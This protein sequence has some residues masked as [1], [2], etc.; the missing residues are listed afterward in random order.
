LTFVHFWN[1]SATPT[2]TKIEL[3]F[4]HFSL[5]GN[6]A[7][8]Q[9]LPKKQEKKGEKIL[10]TNKFAAAFRIPIPIPLALSSVSN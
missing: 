9:N 3:K 1:E 5:A 6:K 2:Q 10:P 7:I 4:T 8:I